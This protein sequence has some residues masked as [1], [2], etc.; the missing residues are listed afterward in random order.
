MPSLMR[1]AKE[2]PF[3]LIAGAMARWMPVSIRTKGLWDAVER[4]NYLAGVL[5]GVDQA[6][7]EGVGEVCVV[8]FGVAGG[9]GL[10]ALQSYASAVERETGIEVKVYG[11]DT[12]EGLTQ[13]CGDYRDHPDRYVRMEYQMD[14]AQLSRRLAPRTRLVL[15]D[16]VETVPKFVRDPSHPPIGF[17]SVDLDLYSST[18]NALRVLDLPG[19][20]LLHRVAMYFDDVGSS[21]HHQWAGEL[22]AIREFNDRNESVKIDR[23]RGIEYGRPFPERGWLK[24]MYVAHDLTA[25]STVAP[26]RGLRSLSLAR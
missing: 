13:P 23:W 16:V 1:I 9:S 17:I 4:P 21:V 14:E 3:R 22:L 5:R 25:I 2:P 26:Q 10:L 15:G 6:R 18:A 8:E 7:E 24:R 12:G 11:F 19:T 20:R